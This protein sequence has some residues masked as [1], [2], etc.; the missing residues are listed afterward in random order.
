MG[1]FLDW[2]AVNAVGALGGLVVF[3][4]SRVLALEGLKKGNFIISSRFRNS[5]D[6]F[7]WVFIGIYDL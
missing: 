2:R 4:D 1:R 6:N 7:A 5:N 3:W